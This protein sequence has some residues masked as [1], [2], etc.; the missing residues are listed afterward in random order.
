MGLPALESGR[1]GFSSFCHSL[2]QMK[3]SIMVLEIGLERQR[4][5][6]EAVVVIQAP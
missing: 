6:L 5:Y 4:D 1:P 3:E 2:Y